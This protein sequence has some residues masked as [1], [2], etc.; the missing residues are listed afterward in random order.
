[1]LLWNDTPSVVVSFG[2]LGRFEIPQKR[3]PILQ[4]VPE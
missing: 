1:M 2:L 4:L 3:Q